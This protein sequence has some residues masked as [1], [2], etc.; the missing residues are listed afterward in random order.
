LIY[1]ELAK[2]SEA[3]EWAAGNLLGRDWPSDS[4]ALHDKAQ[5]RLKALGQL[6]QAEHRQADA[7]RMTAAADRLRSRDLAVYLTWQGEADL[8]LEVKEPIGSVCTYLNRQTPAGGILIGGTLAERTH[9]SYV[10]AQA[11]PGDYEVTVRRVWGRPLG[12][13]ATLEIVQHQGSR[14]ETRHRETIV[15][16]QAHTLTINL[17]EGRRRSVAQVPP[18]SATRQ[19]AAVPPAANS[20]TILDKLRNLADPDLAIGETGMKGGIASTGAP[21]GNRLATQD[22]QRGASGPTAY[23]GKVSPAVSGGMDFTV[24]SSVSADRR[25][26]RLSLAPVFQTV[27]GMQSAAVTANPVIPG[28][29]PP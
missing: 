5:D 16:D 20:R 27:N 28:G 26:V 18:P 24:Q 29:T 14:D 11:F 25:W 13:K 3:M 22:V 4:R 9:Q 8:D 10:A 23:E 7:E 12:S 15:F 17:K 21:V 6:L 2:D 19:T 1:A